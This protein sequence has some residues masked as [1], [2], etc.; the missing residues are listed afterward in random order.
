VICLRTDLFLK[1]DFDIESFLQ[2]IAQS[3]RDRSVFCAGSLVL[4][5][6]TNIYSYLCVDLIFFA[7]PSILSDVLS[8]PEVYFNQ[9]QSQAPL[10]TGP[11]TVEN[12]FARTFILNGYNFEIIRYTVGP[13]FHILRPLSLRKIFD[14]TLRVYANRKSTRLMFLLMIPHQLFFVRFNVFG[15]KIDISMGALEIVPP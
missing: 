11:C 1:S 2:P 12:Y 9:I 8:K 4:G 3:E 13:S 7:R 10:I 5:T 14:R 6:L 15:Y